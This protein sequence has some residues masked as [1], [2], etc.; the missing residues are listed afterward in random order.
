MKNI[1]E[2]LKQKNLIIGSKRVLKLLRADKLK[3]VLVA[4]NC[5]EE[6]VEEIKKYSK[7]SDVDVV[8]LDVPNDE[9]GV[10]CKK[11]FSI[12]VIGY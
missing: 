1:D 6:V 8:E 3:K 5:K 7:V 11:Q 9:L 10:M 2:A 4:K 12:S